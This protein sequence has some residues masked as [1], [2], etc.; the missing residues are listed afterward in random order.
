M[1]R[2]LSNSHPNKGIFSGSRCFHTIR[3][4]RTS[5]GSSGVYCPQRRRYTAQAENLGLR[6]THLSLAPSDG[7]ISA[8]RDCRDSR[9]ANLWSDS[10]CVRAEVH[11]FDHP[12]H[13]VASGSGA[14]AYSRRNISHK[15]P[16]QDQLSCQNLYLVPLP[17]WGQKWR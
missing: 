6:L 15:R 4:R 9:S 11:E 16:T 10:V 1:M 7:R 14:R 13:T 3:L 12:A 8:S 17:T 5:W 2:R